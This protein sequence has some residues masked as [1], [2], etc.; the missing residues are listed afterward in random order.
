MLRA[1]RVT[2]LF[3]GYGLVGFGGDYAAGMLVDHPHARRN[4][5]VNVDVDVDIPDF[6]LQIEPMRSG[7][8]AYQVERRVSVEA[9]ASDLLRLSAGSGEL[10]VEGRPG[11]DRIQ[12]VGRVCASEEAYLEDLQITLERHGGNF[13][14]ATHY[15]DQ[16]RRG[17]WRGNDYARI[18][19]TVEVPLDMAV[20]LEDS[21]GSM[22]VSGTGDLRID[23]SSGEID[24]HDVN[25]AV[26]IDD[27]SGGI[28][29]RDVSGDVE[30]DDGSGGIDLSDIGGTVRL[31]DGSGS[32]SAVAVQGNVVVDDDGSGSISVRDVRGGFEVRSDGS[33]GIRYS[34]VD[35]TVDIPRDKRR[36]GG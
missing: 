35:G 14:L 24:V 22:E 13:E 29:V 9:S 27:S 5:D 7:D 26:R 1:M 28:D 16:G 6:D 33:G 12:A 21:S 8:C 25:G 2:A 11:L 31:R 18:D 3:M 15:P 32:I 19:L 34:G 4:V 17:N 30:V 20:D 10:R 36:H 23:D